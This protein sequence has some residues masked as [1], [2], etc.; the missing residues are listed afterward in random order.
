[1]MQRSLSPLDLHTEQRSG[2]L[3]PGGGATVLAGRDAGEGYEVAPT[4]GGAGSL[5]FIATGLE[6]FFRVK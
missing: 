6:I 1:M 3:L 2:F 4:E 5:E